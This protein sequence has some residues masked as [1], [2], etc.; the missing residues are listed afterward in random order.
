MK[1]FTPTSASYNPFELLR[2]YTFYRT[3]LG[4]VLL[5][6]FEGQLTP[7]VLGMDNPLLF[8]Y[9]AV[10][11]TVFNISTLLL[12]WRVRFSPS[13]KL[14]FNLLLKLQPLLY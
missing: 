6:M 2:V 3:L 13:Q 10:G 1:S 4:I 7:N 12:L 8:L 14:L 11:Y 9:A 5:V